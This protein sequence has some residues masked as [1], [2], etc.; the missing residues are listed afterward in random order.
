MGADQFDEIY[1]KEKKHM[2]SF[3]NWYYFVISIGSLLSVTIF[4][5]IQVWNDLHAKLVN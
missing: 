1:D 4:V 3:F 2:S 5:Y